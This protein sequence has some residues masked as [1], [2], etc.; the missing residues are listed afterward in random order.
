MLASDPTRRSERQDRSA[1][2]GLTGAGPA[3]PVLAQVPAVDYER[4]P[5]VETVLG[6][7]FAPLRSLSV[8]HLGLYWAEIRGKYPHQEIQP[9]LPHEVEEFP[10]KLGVRVGIELMAEP[11]ARPWFIDAT[12]TE[13]LQ[14]QK[15]RFIRNWRQR[16]IPK[17]VYPRYEVLL[18]KFEED[19]GAFVAFLEREDLGR[20]HVDQC[21]VT[22]VNLIEPGPAWSSFGDLS[23]AF[24]IFR[25]PEHR[26]L[27]E[28][29]A[30]L[31][32]THYAMPD[33]AGRLHVSVQ[34]AIRR[35]DGAEVLQ[36]K[37]TARGAPRS[38][39]TSD[40]REWF[41]LGHQWVVHGFDDVVT[42]KMRV[43]WGK[44]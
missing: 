25:T 22:Y 7:Q 16:E 34:P 11:E 5:V 33:R 41:N 10:R 14:V 40:L 1:T 26:F 6:V 21:E 20:P 29:E 18:P 27:P 4:P 8:I 30:V 23:E 15:D 24:T 36:L 28:P 42:P 13:L 17:D 32:N 2:H 9:P 35:A 39:E 43:F 12:S 3:R 31:L 38:S 37:L 44:R 19:W